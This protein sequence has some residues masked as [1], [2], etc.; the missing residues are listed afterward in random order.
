MRIVVQSLLANSMSPWHYAD[1][2]SNDPVLKLEK[3]N[4]IAV[5]NICMTAVSN[6]IWENECTCGIRR[7]GYPEKEKPV[8]L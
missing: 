5:V 4:K 6:T 2:Q 8:A 3:I 1:P 7:L